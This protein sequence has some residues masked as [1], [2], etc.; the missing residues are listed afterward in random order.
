[1]LSLALGAAK[2]FIRGAASS[3]GSDMVVFFFSCVFFCFFSLV[4]VAFSDF[5]EGSMCEGGAV[6]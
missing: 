6:F 5:L 2:F 3:W 1:M 4:S